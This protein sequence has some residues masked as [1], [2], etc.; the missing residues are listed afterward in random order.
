[1][2]AVILFWILT[3]EESEKDMSGQPDPGAG[4][5]GKGDRPNDKIS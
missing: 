5:A 2:V 4:K 1:M 3:E